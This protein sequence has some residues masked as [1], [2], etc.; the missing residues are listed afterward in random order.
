VVAVR[1]MTYNIWQGGR[2]GE[3]LG[4]VVRA[5]APDVLLVNE[6]PKT[7]FIWRWQCRRLA[8]SWGME[9]VTGGRSAGSNMIVVRPG[10]TV[11]AAYST[12]IPQPLFQPRRGVAAARL[13]VDGARLGVVSCHLSLD[14]ERRRREVERVL[15]VS[16]P[17]RG[18][19]VVAGDLNERPRGASWRTLVASGFADPGSDAWLTFPAVAPVKRIDALLVSGPAKVLRHGDP[20][21]DLALQER[22][23]DHRA[24][25]AVL[26]L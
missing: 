3:P 7:P 22:A 9:Y 15:E 23:S 2:A 17:L 19:V 14:P 25:L 21:I 11:E 5:A 24:V 4:E 18:N 10:V 6:C 12:T 20:G 1:V 26:E 16:A 8:E 13:T